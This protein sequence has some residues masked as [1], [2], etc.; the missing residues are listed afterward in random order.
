MHDEARGVGARYSAST[1]LRRVGGCASLLDRCAPTAS[2]GGTPVAACWRGKQ[3]HEAVGGASRLC[4]RP[5]VGR[6]MHLVLRRLVLGE[7]PST[8]RDL[9]RR[10][11]ARAR[12]G[13]VGR[14]IGAEPY[15]PWQFWTAALAPRR[16]SSAIASVWP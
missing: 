1:G 4:S 11:P 13:A 5:R 15:Y 16:S 6:S 3:G 8:F 14:L 12:G 9:L 7:L 2:A 10:P